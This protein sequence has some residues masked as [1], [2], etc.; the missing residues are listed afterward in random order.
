MSFGTCAFAQTS[1]AIGAF[2]FI[3]L[4]LCIFLFMYGLFTKIR[5]FSKSFLVIILIYSIF[6]ILF[7]TLWVHN[8]YNDD[9]CSPPSCYSLMKEDILIKFFGLVP[10]GIFVSLISWHFH[11]FVNLIYTVRPKIRGMMY[12]AM[13]QHIINIAVY[14]WIAFFF[15]KT[16]GPYQGEILRTL[17]FISLVATQITA[18]MFVIFS[19]IVKKS[20][21]DT[22]MY[23]VFNSICTVG[24]ETNVLL[25]SSIVCSVGISCKFLLLLPY[26]IEEDSRLLLLFTITG[27]FIPIAATVIMQYV[28]LQHNSNCIAANNGVFQVPSFPPRLST[29]H[30][31]PSFYNRHFSNSYNSLPSL[32]GSHYSKLSPKFENILSPQ[33]PLSS[34]VSHSTIDGK[35]AKRRNSFVY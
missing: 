14:F 10:E 35:S 2:F 30:E 6:R 11:C 22:T 26:N 23:A 7:F 19:F 34:G 28:I 24:N 27:E 13:A 4:L 20:S 31:E 1:L 5:P 17:P 18:S 12:I 3:M 33:T 9:I 21:P 16:H 8:H 29:V 32:P 25:Y 15:I